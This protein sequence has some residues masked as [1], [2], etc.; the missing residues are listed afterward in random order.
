MI[1][2][3][4]IVAYLKANY[5]EEKLQVE[6]SEAIPDYLYDGWEEEFDGDQD[7]AYSET[8]RGGAESAIRM[9]MEK[10]IMKKFGLNYEQYEA[11]AGEEIWT[12]I[13]GIF[14]CLDKD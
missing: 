6:I 11:I 8:G 3:E 9:D 14:P 2:K 7:M 5:T 13:Y 4:Q 12:T 1:T 10:D